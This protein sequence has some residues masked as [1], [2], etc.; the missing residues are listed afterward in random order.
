MDEQQKQ[1]GQPLCVGLLAH[2]DAGKTTLSEQ[3][4]YQGGAIRSAGRVDD[5]NALLDSDPLE[6]RRGITIF[7]GQSSFRLG[8]LQV[9]LVDTPG[10]VDFSGEMERC[11]PVLDVAIVVISAVEG[12]QGH[13]ETIFHL[14]EQ[15]HIPTMCFINKIDRAG[16]DVPGVMSRLTQLLPGAVILWPEHLEEPHRE[17]LAEQSEA[18]MEAY[19]DGNTEESF[20]LEQARELLQQRLLFPCFCGCAL[21]GEGVDSLLRGLAQLGHV[22]RDST[23]PLSLRVYQVRRDGPF[24]VSFVKVLRGT[25]HAKD[26]VG[27]E[28]INELRR[29]SG[30]KF[31]PLQEATAGMLCGVTGLTVPPGT[32]LG[33]DTPPQHTASQPAL[34]AR[35]LFDPS[36]HPLT[37]LDKLRILEEEEPLLGV[38]W[39]EETQQIRVHIMGAIQ[40]EV[41]QELMAQRFGLDISFGPCQVLYQET[42]AAPVEG[43]GHFEPLRHYAEVHLRLEPAPRGEGITFRSEC[44]TDVLALNWQRLIGTHVLECAHPGA[45]TGSPLTDVRV[46]LLGGR[47]HEKHTEGGDFREA[48]Y[49]AIRQGLFSGES[50]LLEPW[51]AFSVSIEPSL[52]GR[53]MA[54]VQRMGGEFEPPL[55]QG[56]RQVITG[57]AP[58]A[59]MMDYA[60][61]LCDFS[62]GRGILSL[63]LDG[64]ALC[65]NAAQ[66]IE[67]MGYDRERDTARPAGSVFCS[68]GSGYLVPWDEAPS[69]MHTR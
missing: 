47:S 7:S 11:L 27:G 44:S 45:L 56:E 43:W 46:V 66:V 22:Q 29:Y 30:A 16:A 55:S 26:T 3:L 13:T 58:A 14:L 5:Q 4:L 17:Q 59:E 19:F 69:H 62:R 2:V 40:L 36:L 49:R 67:Q 21:S 60:Q 15:Y 1:A 65:H 51:Y 54:D 25:L 39:Q 34:M 8:D 42:L 41:L 6:R 33:E 38:D 12:V 32:V 61:E 35:V 68:H 37:V 28:K 63:R 53:V 52:A 50:V 9:E 31:T 10:H 23:G 24:R 20:W 57:R 64:Y 18:L 48:T